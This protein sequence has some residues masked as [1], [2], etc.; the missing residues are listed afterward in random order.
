MLKREEVED[1]E[2]WR[3]FKS[4][5]LE[6]AEDMRKGEGRDV[7]GREREVNGGVRAREY[8][9][10]R[11]KWAMEGESAVDQREIEENITEEAALCKRE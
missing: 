10:R 6:S 5:I 3:K 1:V 8:Q 11:K 9:Y 7:K 4:Q 2:E